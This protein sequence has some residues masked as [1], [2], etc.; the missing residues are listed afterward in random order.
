MKLL[1]VCLMSII[2]TPLLADAPRTVIVTVSGFASCKVAEGEQEA[3]PFRQTLYAEMM[4]RYEFFVDRHQ[5][6]V[7]VITGC[8]GFSEHVGRGAIRFAYGS[9]NDRDV[10]QYDFKSQWFKDELLEESFVE[11]KRE[12]REF[13]ESKIYENSETN[14]VF[15]SHSWGAWLSLLI[16]EE[17]A[18][19]EFSIKMIT[20]DPI[21]PLFCKPKM[22]FNALWKQIPE[23][24]KFPQGFT[25]E[26]Q[27]E[28]LS[29][30]DLWQHFFQNSFYFLHSSHVD[31]LTKGETSVKLYPNYGSINGHGNIKRSPEVW[32][33]F[34]NEILT[35]IEI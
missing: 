35:K 2:T 32:D 4:K 30:V 24:T 7:E 28:F 5:D 1:I 11:L 27:S 22:Y 15:I 3:S 6:Q 26:R 9:R 20:V 31:V 21:S 16:S 33:F 12:F 13:L 10:R 14:F 29:K 19:E 17:M 18:T 25:R 34:E 8:F 23:C